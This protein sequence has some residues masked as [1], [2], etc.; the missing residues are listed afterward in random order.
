MKRK[1]IDR[2]CGNI[3]NLAAQEVNNQAEFISD[4]VNR[5]S[6]WFNDMDVRVVGG[7]VSQSAVMYSILEDLLI[8]NA[9]GVIN[10]GKNRVDQIKRVISV[11]SPDLDARP[12]IDPGI[13][14]DCSKYLTV[15]E[16]LSRRCVCGETI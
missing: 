11:A 16:M 3:A 10:I 9:N 6:V 2:M 1:E 15:D 7:L 14:A 12:E 4:E 8:D 5:H 13:C